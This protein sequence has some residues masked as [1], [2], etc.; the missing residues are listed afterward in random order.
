MASGKSNY[1]AGACEDAIVRGDSPLA[2]VTSLWV[3]LWTATLNAASTVGTAGE[4]AG[5][6]YARVEVDLTTDPFTTDDPPE[7]SADIVFPEATGTW[8]SVTYV[9]LCDAVTGGN[10]L[11]WGQLAAPTAINSGQTAKFLA[12]SLTLSET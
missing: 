4:V 8:G 2:T 11:Y 1:W 9:A 12:G 5:S 7:N 6:G 10:I 3:A